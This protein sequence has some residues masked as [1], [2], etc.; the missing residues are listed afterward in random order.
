[1]H[2]ERLTAPSHP[3]Y[4]RAMTLYQQS[5]PLHEQREAPSQE[6]ILADDAYHFDLIWEEKTF[7]GLILYWETMDFIYVEHLCIAQEKRGKGCGQQVLSFLKNRQ[8]PIVL[9]IDPPSDAISIR[10][11]GFYQRC[12]F[13]ANPYPHVHPPY[14]RGRQ[15]H[16]LL[17]MSCPR[18]SPRK[19]TISSKPFCK[20]GS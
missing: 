16:P 17:L 19:N 18:P 8:K 11:K 15:G 5:F 10:R 12:G 13:T 9:E 6:A 20:P 2:L 3:L 1:M 14:H 7:T 4:R